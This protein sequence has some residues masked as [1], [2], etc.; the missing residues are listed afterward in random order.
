MSNE[1]K[2][3]TEWIFQGPGQMRALGS[4]L[5]WSQTSLGAV[6]TWPQ[7]LRTA[8]QTVLASPFPAILLWGPDLIQIYNDGYRQLMG[9][10]HP[11]GLGQATQQCW[12]EVWHINQ[13]L[14]QR[15]WAGESASFADALYPITRTGQLEDAWFTLA[16]SPVRQE[17]GEVGGILVTVFET[18]DRVLEQRQRTQ[19]QQALRQQQ[20]HTRLAVEAAGLATWEWD[21]VTNQVVWNEHHFRLLG[22]AI[23]PNPLPAEAFVRHLH[24]ADADAI[25]AQLNQAITQRTVYDAEFRVVRDDGVTRWMSGYGQVTQEAD[26]QPI[27]ASGIMFDITDRRA[28]QEALR[29]S[30]QQF[31]AFVMASSDVVYQMNPDWTQMRSLVGRNFIPTTTDPSRTWL[32]TY[33]HP[34]DQSRVL[35]VIREAI[36]TKRAFDLEHRVVQV[37]GNLGWTHSRAIPLLNEAG[38]ITGWLGTAHD[39]TDRKR[40]ETNLAFL[41]EVS[42]DLASLTTI[43]ETMK[44]LGA[45]IGSHFQVSN[46]A[47]GEVDEPHEVMSVAHEWRGTDALSF[48]GQ[49]RISDFLDDDLHQTMRAGKVWVMSDV[50][51]DARANA[52]SIAALGIGAMASVPF[53]REGEWLFNL[54]LYDRQAR[55]WREDEI[56]LLRQ[57]ASYIWTRLERARA[58]EALSDSEARL[59]LA[60]RAAELGTFIWHVAEDR[61][62]EDALARIHFGLPADSTVSLA[63]ALMTTFHPDDGP[64][65]A[66]AVTRATDP[67]GSGELHEEFRVIH[68]DGKER[69]LAV[70]AITAFEGTPPV[71]ARL[72]GVLADVTQRKQ[73]E[74]ILHASKERF[75]SIANLVPDLLWDSKPDG[76]TNWYNQRWL[77]YT[78]QRFEEAIG[79]GWTQAIHP[80]DREGS[81]RRY[82][83]AVA[84][85]NSLRQEHRLRRHD[86][87]YHWF[88]VTASPL[89]DQ[90]GQVIKMYGAATDIDDIKRLETTLRETDR[91][92]DE[93]LAM[94]AHE[95][96]N[97]MS[98]IRSGLQILTLTDEKDQT[99]GPPVGSE[100]ITEST[101]AE[102]TVAMMSRQTDQL[103]RLVD[104]LLDVSRISQG[105][106]D[107][108]MR[109]VN[110]VEVVDQATESLKGL[111]REQGRNL[112][113]TLPTAP[114]YLEGDATRLTQ[115]VANLLTNGARYTDERGQVWV[116]LVHHRQE[117]LLEVRDNGLGLAPDQ[118]SAIFD[119]FMQVD[120][121]V[122]RS[123]GG[124][125]LGLT[126]VKRLVEMHGGRVEAQSAGLG[127]GSTFRVH[128]PTLEI[129][130]EVNPKPLDETPSRAVQDRI[131]VIDDNADAA[132]TLAMLLKLKGYEAHTRHSGR[133]GLEAAETLQPAAIVLDLGMPDMDGYAT[134]R[135]IR[136]QPWGGQ[137]PVIALSGYGQEED[138]QRTKEAGFSGHLVKPVDLAGLLSLLTEVLSNPKAG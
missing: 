40:R 26:G 36:D 69:W 23:Q 102:S 104:D 120:N 73:A 9:N 46:V 19:V 41:A 59:Q 92:K 5:D 86:G 16:Y 129:A 85:G 72:I 63:E 74:Q 136:E 56:E 18:T 116:S 15:V 30:E 127:K 33:I 90:T 64:S 114:I 58:E 10:K 138:R 54:T 96:R 11:A 118:L 55:Y 94:L 110:L 38:D 21:L 101:V 99:T 60:L 125:G 95:L 45:K 3:H 103:V 134:C 4:V 35:E 119:L 78:G 29:E 7:S 71:A 62:Q 88:V 39:V 79:W 22:M 87:V 50:M 130:P 2:A 137:V 107:L 98:T 133:A 25:K 48:I 89:K 51:N 32:E 67:A 42:Q 132:F 20:Q 27:R 123:K 93:F 135:A 6:T 70:S 91:R 128:L 52:E 105:K 100:T 75:E 47:F 61:T 57:T 106:I 44:A 1:S 117:A 112:Q 121:S 68:P 109:R 17:S 84:A 108:K 126:L 76:S 24:P 43:D 111:Y 77:D 37:N 28:T 124:L 80:D 97:P 49:Y 113:V 83:Q 14:Y 34:D 131:L 82:G 122:A 65:Y 31:R 81:A 8:A 66:A 115:V 12:P 53:A 13:P